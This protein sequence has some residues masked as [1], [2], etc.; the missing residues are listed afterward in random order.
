MNPLLSPTLIIADVE[1]TVPVFELFWIVIFV[2][3][4]LLTDSIRYKSSREQ[5]I[6]VSFEMARLD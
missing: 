1:V 2:M 4:R 3:L 5:F 6:D